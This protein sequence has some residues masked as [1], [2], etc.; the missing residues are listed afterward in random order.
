MKTLGAWRTPDDGHPAKF[1]P[2]NFYQVTHY[3]P[4]TRT[5]MPRNYDCAA[6]DGGRIEAGH[7]SRAELPTPIRALF[8]L[9]ASAPEICPTR[10]RHFL[11]KILR[12]IVR[13]W[14]AGD[15]IPARSRTSAFCHPT[16]QQRSA[17]PAPAACVLPRNRF[18]KSI[19]SMLF[20]GIQ[21]DRS[22]DFSRRKQ[23]CF[24]TKRLQPGPSANYQAASS[25]GTQ[26]RSPPALA[27]SM[28]TELS[29]AA[30]TIHLMPGLICATKGDQRNMR[31][32][33]LGPRRPLP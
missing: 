11:F 21:V 12:V 9:S 20:P 18:C 25:D 24:A 3:G 16:T 5:E 8:R 33:V 14:V 28:A 17:R 13:A 6:E 19:D 30:P 22:M 1:S 15:N 10:W 31:R 29:P 32:K 4:S 7:D 26:K 23:V 27:Q 2:A